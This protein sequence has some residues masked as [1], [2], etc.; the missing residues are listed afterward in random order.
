M[1]PVGG[2]SWLRELV[3]DLGHALRDSGVLI[4]DLQAHRRETLLELLAARAERDALVLAVGRLWQVLITIDRGEGRD[5]WIAEQR[6]IGSDLSEL[7]W[8]SWV[9]SEELADHSADAALEAATL[10]D[11]AAAA[12][13][14]DTAITN[15]NGIADSEEALRALVRRWREHRK[16]GR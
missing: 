9:V 1:S 12:D 10:R 4:T 6:R 11:L 5:T 3:R 13:V 14:W 15:L 2:T 8:Y 16:A 7:D